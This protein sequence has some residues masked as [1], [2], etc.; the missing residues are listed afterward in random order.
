MSIILVFPTPP[1]LQNSNGN[2]LWE[3]Y[4][5]GG[6]EMAVYIENGTKLAPNYTRNM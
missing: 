4:M 3:C 2:P 6:G 1:L 5:Y